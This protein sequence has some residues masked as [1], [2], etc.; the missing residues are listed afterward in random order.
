MPLPLPG[1]G[2]ACAAADGYNE[3]HR[4]RRRDT[5]TAVPGPLQ[6]ELPVLGAAD[7]GVPLGL[8]KD[9][10][11]ALRVLRV[12]YRYRIWRLRDLDAR[13][14]GRKFLCNRASYTAGS[15]CHD[16]DFAVEA[17]RI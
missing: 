9:E 4:N 8:G 12:A 7:E 16:G 15:P 3:A 10:G 13:S 14:V 11:W 5:P 17:R 1:D 6:V 2:P